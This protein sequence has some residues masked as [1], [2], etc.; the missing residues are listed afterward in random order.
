LVLTATRLPPAGV[1]PG[2]REGFLDA[3]WKRSWVDAPCG[4]PSTPWAGR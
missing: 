4:S 1:L 3:R 2:R